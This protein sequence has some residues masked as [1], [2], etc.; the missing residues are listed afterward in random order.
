MTIKGAA[1]TKFAYVDGPSKEEAISVV[2]YAFNREG[3]TWRTRAALPLDNE[4]VQNLVD[5]YARRMAE[6]LKPGDFPG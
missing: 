3:R 5:S 4:N 2:T 6:T 1:A